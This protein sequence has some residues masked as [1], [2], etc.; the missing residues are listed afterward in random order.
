[1]SERAEFFIEGRKLLAK[2]YRYVASGLNN[3]FLLNGVTEKATDYGPMVH[4]ENINGLH[5][6][7]GLHIIEKPDPMEGAE[8]RF[9]R[10][11]MQMTQAQLAKLL[12]VTDQTVANYEK[13]KSGKDGFG[14]ADAF[15]RTFYLLRIIPE[16]TQVKVIK[17]LLGAPNQNVRRKLSELSRHKIVES[18]REGEDYPQIAA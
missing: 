17:P 16:Q 10:K 18:W 5:H 6:A 12:S 4:I 3:I 7:I 13:G 11:Q 2:P 9:L 8:F 14:P 1:M 15:M